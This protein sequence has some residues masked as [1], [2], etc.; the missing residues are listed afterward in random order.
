MREPSE[1]AA[2]GRARI[3]ATLPVH[4]KQLQITL[5]LAAGALDGPDPEAA[6][7]FLDALSSHLDAALATRN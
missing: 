5:S 6:Y 3:R 1:V 2:A 4:L 7:G